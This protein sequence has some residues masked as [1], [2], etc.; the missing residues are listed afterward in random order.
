M[1]ARALEKPWPGS[2]VRNCNAQRIATGYAFHPGQI[3]Q[4]GVV[5]DLDLAIR[6]R[7]LQ[8]PG[9]TPGGRKPRL[10]LLLSVHEVGNSRKKVE[11]KLEK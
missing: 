10:A 4:R 7:P 9:F 3:L 1:N 2:F 8:S 6:E 5:D 11:Q